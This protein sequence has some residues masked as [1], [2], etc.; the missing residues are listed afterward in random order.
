MNKTPAE[1]AWETM[2]KKPPRT[3]AI[4]TKHR[5]AG[6]KKAA[7]KAK[8]RQW[9]P[10]KVRYLKE[11]RGNA[12]LNTCIVCGDSRQFVLQT[13]HADRKREVEVMLCANCH[14]TVRRGTL[15]DLENAHKLTGI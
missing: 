7:D 1:K 9:E 8:G 10:E 2:R 5:R 15:E 6:A 14:D 13:H 12:V 4:Y 3:K 11:L